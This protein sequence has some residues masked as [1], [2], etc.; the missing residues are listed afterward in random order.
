[1]E[2]KYERIQVI[3]SDTGEVLGNTLKTDRKSVV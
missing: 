3:N 1:M 2:N